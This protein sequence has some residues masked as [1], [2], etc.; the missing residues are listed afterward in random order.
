MHE[1]K[2]KVLQKSNI[3]V[4]KLLDGWAR[5]V[6]DASDGGG[7]NCICLFGIFL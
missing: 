6:F 1:M 2:T 4:L 7:D 5:V 3:C